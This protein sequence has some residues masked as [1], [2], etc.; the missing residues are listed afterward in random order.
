MRDGPA[1]AIILSVSLRGWLDRSFFPRAARHLEKLLKRTASTV[2]LR[3]EAV[4]ESELPSLHRLLRRL[5]PYG[6]RISIHLDR[7]LRELVRVDSSV[8]HLVLD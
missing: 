7:R 5:A 2:T 8:F 1:A 3:I 6:D 4:H